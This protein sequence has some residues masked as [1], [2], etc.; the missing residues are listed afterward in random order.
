ML[1]G[2]TQPS[3]QGAAPVAVEV[4]ATHRLGPVPPLVF[5]VNT[6]SWDEQ[7]FPG[8]LEDWPLTFDQDALRKVKQAGIRFLR[9]PGG[10]DGDSYVWDSEINSRLRM[11]TDEFLLFTRLVGAEAS[12]GV[13][14]PAGPELAAR[15]VRYVNREKGYA[16]RYWEVGDEEYF[17]VPAA[18]YARRVVEFARAM[19]AEDPSIK[20]GAGVS[21]PRASWT[22]EVLREAGE[23]LD[24]V[25][26]NWYP[27][28]PRQEDDARL[29]A[30]PA[31]L[32][33]HL[34]TL[35]E[36]LRR[37][38]PGRSE[39]IEIHIGGYS[40]VSAY[41]GP[42]ST[43][44]V[45]AL[46][47]ADSLGVMLEQ[48]VAA[49]GYWALHNVYP[50]R[51]G[52]YGLLS[53]TPDNVPHPGYYVFPLYTRHFGKELVSVTSP[54]PA[55]S[56]YGSV[57][58]ETKA[59]YVLLIN[60]DPARPRHVRL[61]VRGF[62]AEPLGLG[63]ILSD[64]RRLEPLNPRPDPAG[65]FEVPAYS[66]VSIMLPPAQKGEAALDRPLPAVAA[67][68]SSS[69]ELGPAW[70][71]ESAIDGRPDTRWASRIWHGGPEWLEVDLG[72]VA[73]VQGL[74]LNWEL[75]ATHY[76]VELSEDGRTWTTAY[77]TESG[78]G[79]VERV[80]LEPESA[81]YVRLVLLQRP[82]ARGTRFGHSLWTAG[83][84][85]LWEVEVFGNLVR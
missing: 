39:E 43:S 52:D 48:G 74:R 6:A 36:W 19:K 15:W 24:F 29:L 45:H 12:I 84:F 76:R 31:E 53:S 56:A 73:R 25:V 82:Q 79:G 3:V 83:S 42:Q 23:V 10:N 68:A 13:N 17:S 61:D 46:W 54:D 50:P 2:P 38:V 7:L 21:V 47:M 66:A 32:R 67:R 30:T 81:R 37:E 85:S 59:L 70:G 8:S 65:G 58:P 35:R 44:I 60:K 51:H 69:A 62:E 49:A 33:S 1:A 77:E 34:R 78:Q 28:A 22:R 9:Y 40:S 18:E 57:D 80:R 26:Y 55:L 27:Q 4:D 5:G 20:V 75:H 16:V 71:P 11:D 14:Y 72:A 41:P 64:K 63:W